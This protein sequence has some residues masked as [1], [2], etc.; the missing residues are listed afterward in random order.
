MKR[1]TLRQAEWATAILLTIAVVS[2]M[3]VRALHA[4]GLWRDE[5]AAVQLARM[6]TF[7][8]IAK[9]FQYEAFPLLFPTVVR[10][11]TNVFGTSDIAFRMFGLAVGVLLLAVLWFNAWQLGGAPPLLSLSLLGLNTSVLVWGT[12]VRG[13]GLGMVLIF[14]VILINALACGVRRAGEHYAR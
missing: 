9:N 3:V 5:C 7:T 10:G 8:D 2:L 4:G 1:P 14:L 6:P 13:Y 12:S 11:Y